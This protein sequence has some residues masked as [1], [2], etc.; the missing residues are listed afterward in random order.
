M[1]TI[2]AHNLY[3]Y[4]CDVC[5]YHGPHY[6]SALSVDVVWFT[7]GLCDLEFEVPLD[8]LRD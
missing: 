8:R 5:G 2:F 6:W 1:T 7:C 3:D 4:P